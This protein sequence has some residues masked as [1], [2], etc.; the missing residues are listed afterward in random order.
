MAGNNVNPTELQE[1]AHVNPVNLQ[2]QDDDNDHTKPGGKFKMISQTPPPNNITQPGNGVDVPPAELANAA[3]TGDDASHDVGQ[4]PPQYNLRPGRDHSYSHR[5]ASSMN[6]SSG[7]KS[8]DPYVQLLQFASNNMETC[9][10][11]MFSYIFGFM[12]TQMTASWGIKRHGQK[13]TN[14]LFSMFCQLD[15]KTVF[16]P[17]DA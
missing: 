12:M 10:G 6:A 1:W 13:A 3:M 9:L 17:M 4:P 5:L 7:T 14:A 2:E 8:Y 16:E 15:D 11:D